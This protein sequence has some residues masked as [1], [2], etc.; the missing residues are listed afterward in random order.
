MMICDLCGIELGI[1]DW[2]YCPHGPT[3]QREAFKAYLDENISDE[4]V[5]IT[6]AGDRNKLMRPHWEKDYLVRIEERDKSE[7]YYKELN[8]RRA[9]RAE[10]ER[11]ERAR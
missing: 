8:Q 7:N 2:P 10:I 11:K 5:W 6:N 3:R 4:P 1:G 9:H